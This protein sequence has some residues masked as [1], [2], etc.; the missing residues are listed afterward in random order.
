M[1]VVS[2][3]MTKRGKFLSKPRRGVILGFLTPSSIIHI[4]TRLDYY[5]VIWTRENCLF[6][7]G[8]MNGGE[9]LG[10]DV[11]RILEP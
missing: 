9:S 6:F 1:N 5:L 2:R 10:C 8:F 7:P 4:P 3:I 11:P